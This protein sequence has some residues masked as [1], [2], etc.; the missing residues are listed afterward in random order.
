MFFSRILGYSIEHNLKPKVVFL[1]QLGMTQGQV[2]KL[3]AAF[4]QVLGYS[5][6]QNLTPKVEWF[7]QLGMTKGQVAKLIAVFPRILGL[8]IE[9]NLAP[10]QALLQE[11]LGAQGVLEVVLRQPQTMGMSYQ[12]LSKRLMILVKLNQTAKLVTAMKMTRETFKRR[13]LDDLL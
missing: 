3:I 11:V 10:K 6:K 8:S 13:F 12:R 7:L 2:A 5:I 4:P 1:L 9:K